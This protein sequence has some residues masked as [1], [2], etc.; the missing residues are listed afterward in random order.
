[1]EDA[2]WRKGFSIP[3]KTQVLVPRPN[4]LKTMEMLIGGDGISCM[5]FSVPGKTQVKPQ[6]NP[7]PVAN[8]R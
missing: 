5:R 3:G 1:M 7:K 6:D 8:R 2:A 4:Q